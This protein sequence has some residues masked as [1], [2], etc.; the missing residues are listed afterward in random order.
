MQRLIYLLVYPL[1]WIISKLPFPLFYAVSDFVYFIV[2]RVAGYRKKVVRANLKTSFPEKSEKEIRKIEKTFYAHMCDMFLEMIKTMGIS[3]D[4]MKRRFTFTNLE[5]LQELESRNK[6][7]MLMFSHY[8]S[9]EWVICLNDYIKSKGYGIYQPIGNR[10]FDNLVRNIRNKFGT[11]LIS[12]RETVDMVE[13]NKVN[14]QLSMYGIISDQ[15]PMLSKTHHWVSFM[16]VMVPAHTGAELLC[17][18]LDLPA[19][20]LKVK[21]LKRGYYQGTFEVLTENPKSMEDYQLTDKFMEMVEDQI[22]EAPEYY[23]WTHKR[24]KHR[25]KVPEKYVKKEKAFL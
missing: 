16:G 21:K 25:H 9:W 11:T 1:L 24:Y 13:K 10:Y 7:V 22:R 23:L 20:F 8:A 15:S 12:T 6:S 19:V 4:E 3:G 17:K 18:R 2:Y 5:V 14:K